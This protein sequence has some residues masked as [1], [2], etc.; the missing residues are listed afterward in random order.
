MAREEEPGRKAGA[1]I[2]RAIVL[3]AI[4]V[5]VASAPNHNLGDGGSA[6][7][8]EL[9]AGRYVEA[10]R[11]AREFSMHAGR[12]FGAMSLESARARDLLV[13]ALIAGGRSSDSATLD[14]AALVVEIKERNLGSH[15][16]DTAVS[17]RNLAAVHARRG[18]FEVASGLLQR[19][20]AAQADS[21]PSAKADTLDE[22]AFSLIHLGRFDNAKARLDES[23]AIR[24][25]AV[26]VAPL[27]LAYTLELL[28]LLHRHAG[29]YADAVEPLARAEALRRDQSAD[30]PTRV[31]G[32]E[33]R[34]DVHFLMGDVLRAQ[35]AWSYALDL[36]ERT[37][38]SE[39]PF[40]PELMRRLATAAS[41][42]GELAEARQLRERALVLSDGRFAPCDPARVG[43]LI[44]LAVSREYDGEYGG[45]RSLLRRALSE[46]DECAA[47]AASDRAVDAQATIVFNDA[48]LAQKMGDMAE[49][50]QLF[51]RALS[52]WQ[53]N[54]GDRHPYVALAL[55]SLATVA[56]AQGEWARAR[57]LYDRALAIREETLGGNHP[58]VAATLADL[59]RTLADL[60]D[61]SGARRLLERA[62]TIYRT[63]G[64][65]DVPDHLAQALQLR[66]ALEMRQG[67]LA[68]SRASLAEALAERE[69]LFGARHP[70]VAESRAAV[71]HV[72]FARGG[73]DA[74]FAAA[75][76]AEQIG[77]EHLRFTVRYLPERQAVHYAATRPRGLDLALSIAVS[78][79]GDPRR[80]LDALVHSRG[81]VLDELA[82]RAR[83]AQVS[84]GG[85][86]SIV[87]EVSRARQR[88]ANLMVRSLSEPLP[89]GQLDAA[90]SEKEDAER[91]LAELSAVAASEN[92]RFAAGL[93]DVR[94]ELPAD[95][96]LVSFVQFVQTQRSAR[97]GEVLHSLGA[98]VT[99]PESGSVRF[100][101]LGRATEIEPLIRLWRREAGGASLLAG[102]GT[103]EAE[104]AYRAAALNLRRAVWDPLLPALVGA[105][106]VFLVLDGLLNLVNFAAL[107]GDDGRALVEVGPSFHYLATERD[108]V[109]RAVPNPPS[110][111]LL[112]VGGA[113][114]GEADPSIVP[115]STARWNNCGGAA[116]I[117]FEALPGTLAEVSEIA[118]L[119]AVNRAGATVVSGLGAS[120]SAIKRG[121]AGHSVIHLA[122]HGFFLGSECSPA[123]A[124]TRGVGGLSMGPSEPTAEENPLLLSGLALAGANRRAMASPDE[125]DG[126]LTAEEVASLDLSAVEWAVLSACDTGVGEIKAGEGVFGL[127]R[128]FQVAGART[129]IMSLWSVEDQATRA[130]MRALYEARFQKRLSTADAVHAAS[131]AVLQDRR[132][133]GQST[134]P[135]FWAA[136]VAA[137]DWR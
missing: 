6:V 136:F 83:L 128:A 129:V 130:W 133:K 135:F 126:I 7:R 43:Y 30:H 38:G 53:S 108:L 25:D 115:P 122:T 41:A 57:A 34:G 23:M 98:F 10:A 60:G 77:L 90:R 106:R 131:L 82:A 86:E 19:A 132:A 81:V 105:S 29:S 92:A 50:E 123:A 95:A 58:Q 20:L 13:E 102:L 68:R 36:A 27:R 16:E 66:G 67:D 111:T 39:H 87:T 49:A 114:F 22:L 104:H 15:H 12:H 44:D 56:A 124:G 70:L 11:L 91:R 80:A 31:F 103:D 117:R 32:L 127:R 101:S 42:L 40:V 54:L 72:D 24:E 9:D 8:R 84:E 121:V 1:A 97:P 5:Q 125:D 48:G 21:P 116:P 61:L 113:M 18:E 28:G 107:P 88:F 65:R 96:V 100:I 47:T 14:T 137:G 93:A 26:A 55:D 59:A 46:R 35:E 85:T 37:L 51:S 120:E 89:Q 118:K 119:W 71:A 112:A 73:F 75:L 134:H 110:P 78:G 63:A 94:R 109:A 52:L 62:L 4:L 79:K 3:S 99:R 33:V 45:A 74:A 17:L 69:R 76:D 2:A 64:S